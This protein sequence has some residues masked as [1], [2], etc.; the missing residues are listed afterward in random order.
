MF[1]S[2]PIMHTISTVW[3]EGG[4]ISTHAAI[5]ASDDARRNVMLGSNYTFA[6]KTLVVIGMALTSIPRD[7][8]PE[9][10]SLHRPGIAIRWAN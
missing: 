6:L 5:D 9:A 10:S 7:H 4:V 8:L 1:I 3:E 2:L